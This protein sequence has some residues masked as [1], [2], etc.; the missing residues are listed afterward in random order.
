SAFAS[1]VFDPPAGWEHFTDEQLGARF[2]FDPRTLPA[3][4][5]AFPPEVPMDA[6]IYDMQGFD[7]D[8]GSNVIV[9]FHR[10]QGELQGYMTQLRD[11]LKNMNTIEYEID[12]EMTQMS[13][14]GQPFLAFATRVSNLNAVQLYLGRELN[15]YIMLVNL[16]TIGDVTPEDVITY[17]KAKEAG[18]SAPQLPA[19]MPGATQ[20]PETPQEVIAPNNELEPA[21]SLAP[22]RAA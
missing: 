5:A 11:S 14:A 2:S 8:T 16:M 22:A 3:Q 7:P 19:A 15:G 20:P 9:R 10:Y 13:V 4:G 21:G 18:D 17:F 12:D 6:V 1:I